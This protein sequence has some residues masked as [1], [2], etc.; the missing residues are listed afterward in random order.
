MGVLISTM[1]EQIEKHPKKTKLLTRKDNFRSKLRESS[2]PWW[3]IEIRISGIKSRA[4]R[5]IQLLNQ[6]S[7]LV[8][9]GGLKEVRLKTTGTRIK[10]NT[11]ETTEVLPASE[12]RLNLVKTIISII[13]IKLLIQLTNIFT[14]V[15]IKK[16]WM[17][18]RIFTLM[19]RRNLGKVLPS[20]CLWG[21]P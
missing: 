12:I 20:H 19:I 6:S 7:L 17:I 15:R 5:K 18:V 13:K 11:K 3:K 2:D 4:T 8:N 10:G 1:H 16:E 21:N 14:K 9:I